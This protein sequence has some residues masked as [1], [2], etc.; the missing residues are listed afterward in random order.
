MPSDNPLILGVDGD[1]ELALS[2]LWQLSTYVC[3]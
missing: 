1:G 3:V 2:L